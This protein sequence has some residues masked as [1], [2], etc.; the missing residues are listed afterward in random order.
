MAD[1]KCSGEP[2]CELC[3]LS[4][5]QTGIAVRVR[6]LCAAPE[7]QSRLRELGFCEDQVIRLITNRTGFICQVCNS[8][9]ALSEQM[10]AMIMVEPMRPAFVRA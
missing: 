5:V 9:L 7:I 2:A 10:A 8:R 1:L 3:P 6:Q 4:R